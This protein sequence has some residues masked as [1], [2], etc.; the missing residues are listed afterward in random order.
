[1]KKDDTFG[2]SVVEAWHATPLGTAMA[3][4]VGLDAARTPIPAA[5]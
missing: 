4:I 2:I 3:R 1:M 5:S